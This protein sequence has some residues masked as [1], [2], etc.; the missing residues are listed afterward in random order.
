MNRFLRSNLFQ[1]FWAVAGAVSVRTKVL[2]IVLGTVILLGLFAIVQVRR[3]MWMILEEEVERQGLAIGT[4]VAE[5]TCR[6]WTRPAASVSIRCCTMFSNTPTSGITP[7]G[8]IALHNGAGKLLA[9]S[10][11]VGTLPVEAA[12]RSL[13]RSTRIRRWYDI[14]SG[15]TLLLRA[16]RTPEG[17]EAIARVGL[18]DRECA[19][20]STA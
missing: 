12:R 10:F 20:A 9:H 4:Y 2:G 17:R 1:R 11:G 6:C 7:S 16:F 13:R 8:V 5:A 15:C 3:S 14:E 18:A 19:P